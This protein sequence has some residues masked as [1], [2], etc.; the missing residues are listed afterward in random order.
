MVI[1]KRGPQKFQ[2]L[3][4]TLYVYAYT[5]MNTHTPHCV[6]SFTQIENSHKPITSMV[7]HMY[8]CDTAIV[9]SNI[10]ICTRTHLKINM[11]KKNIPHVLRQCF[12]TRLSVSYIHKH[13]N[14]HK[15][16]L[17]P[18]FL[19]AFSHT[20]WDL[21]IRFVKCKQIPVSFERWNA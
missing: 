3:N 11:K 14:T 7:E 20:H 6:V 21:F 10:Y 12:R 4:A 18:S 9:K 2:S 8:K 13:M 17:S 16:S 1:K 15:R 19:F 5:D